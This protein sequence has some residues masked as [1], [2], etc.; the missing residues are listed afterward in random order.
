MIQYLYNLFWNW[1]TH[2]KIKPSISSSQDTYTTNLTNLTK[3]YSDEKYYKLHA[4]IR[5]FVPLNPEEIL[6]VHTLSL[7][8]LIDIVLLYNEHA[9]NMKNYFEYD[10][11]YNF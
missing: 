1:R 9:K 10:D 8:N 7:Q 2:Y 3:E 11:D 6:Y 4:K 5:N